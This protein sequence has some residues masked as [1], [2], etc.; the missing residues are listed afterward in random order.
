MET[1]STHQNV[2]AVVLHAAEGAFLLVEAAG[3][4]LVHQLLQQQDLRLVGV[5]VAPYLLVET[6]PSKMT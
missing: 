6:R 4:H 5:A 3:D 1:E 2:T